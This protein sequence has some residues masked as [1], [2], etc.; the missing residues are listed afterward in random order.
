[1]L[2]PLIPSGL[3]SSA[4]APPSQ[5]SHASDLASIFQAPPVSNSLP[6]YNIPNLSVLPQPAPPAQP[7]FSG[8]AQLQPSQGYAGYPAGPV[9][10]QNPLAFSTG[11]AY[12]PSMGLAPNQSAADFSA[13]GTGQVSSGPPDYSAFQSAPPAVPAGP[14]A[15]LNTGFGGAPSFPQSSNPFF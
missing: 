11:A 15:G 10:G 4:P 13:F 9:S 3:P 6:N 8:L 2:V 5:S 7:G 14:P 1:M 12:P